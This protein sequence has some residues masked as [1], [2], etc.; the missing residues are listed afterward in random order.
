MT[1][2]A[3]ARRPSTVHNTFAC[4]IFFIFLFLFN[5]T[6]KGPEGHYHVTQQSQCLTQKTSKYTKN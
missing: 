6:D 3:M 5:I 1:Y 4:N 2:F